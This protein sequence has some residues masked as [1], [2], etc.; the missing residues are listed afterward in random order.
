MR[1]TR[2]A[3][4]VVLTAVAAG[5]S[6]AHAGGTAGRANMADAPAAGVAAPASARAS[7]AKRG[8]AGAT[9]RIPV[10]PVPPSP[11]TLDPGTS[12]AVANA[13]LIT[14]R[15]NHVGDP[16]VATAEAAAVSARGDTVIPAGAAFYGRVAAIAPAPNPHAHAVLRLAFDSVRIGD[17][18]YPV[19]V[20]VVSLATTLQ[21]RGVTAGTAAKVGAGAV[22]GG[23][24]GRL[25]GR[26]TTGTV[27]GALA[28]GAGGAVWANATR[29][30][31]VVLP[32][33]GTIRLKLTEPFLAAKR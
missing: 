21:G 24:A 25:I 28:G 17:R 27:I 20:E 6:G 8:L 11:P 30:L 13:A 22:V 16:V 5:C 18:G 10:P 31:D 1:I 7:A 4:P 9:A 12:L 15:H 33:G 32:K 29:N 2:I 26:S 3:L 19:H 23:V 14:S